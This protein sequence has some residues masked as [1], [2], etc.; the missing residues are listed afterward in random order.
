MLD[1]RKAAGFT[2]YFVICSGTNPRQIR[3]IADGIMEALAADGV[4]PAHVEGYDR[5]E[6]ILLDYFDF[7][8]HIFA[9]E[10]RV[11]YGL[12]RL[13]GNAE[14]IEVPRADL[15]MPT[16]IA[17]QR[18]R[19]RYDAS[20][21]RFVDAVLVVLLA[22]ACAACAS[23]SST[24]RRP[25]LPRCWRSILPLTPPLCDR[26]GDPLPAWRAISSRWRAARAAGARPVSS[27][28][29]RA[30]GAYDGALRAIVHALKYDG[31]RSLARPLARADARAAPTCS[32]ARRCVVPV[33]LHPS[34]RRERGFNQAADLARHLRLPVVPRAAARSRDADAGR[35]AGRARHGNVRDAFALH[36]R[37]RAA[38]TARRRPGR[39]CEH[40]RA[41]LEACARALKQAGVARGARAYG[42]TGTGCEGRGSAMINDASLAGTA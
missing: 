25:G 14:R 6:W 32:T 19:H 18:L 41:T 34:R 12:E 21:A 5:S 38:G 2:D 30:I 7:I 42:R 31:R 24:R 33:P 27:I 20:L 40:H 16:A 8:V 10:T 9:P 13:W 29:R 26:C 36:A 39:R 35:A 1:L 37:A 17:M 11:F 28:A 3:A 15:P 22:P 4:K 23:C